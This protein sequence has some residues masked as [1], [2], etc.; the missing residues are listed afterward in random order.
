MSSTSHKSDSR[1]TLEKKAHT[2]TH[3]PT[4]ST[5]KKMK[6]INVNGKRFCMCV[7]VFVKLLHAFEMPTYKI[8]HICTFTFV[9]G[10]K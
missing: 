9:S 5:M 10:E 7:C 4:C 6:H 3:K 8:K 2:H 1:G